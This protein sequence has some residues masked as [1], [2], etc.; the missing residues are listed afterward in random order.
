M[1]LPTRSTLRFVAVLIAAAALTGF[2]R[3][4]SA[5]PLVLLT[6]FPTLRQQHSLTCE[7]SSASMGTRGAVT[8]ARIMAAMSRSPNPNLGFRGNPDGQQRHALVDYGVYAAPVQSALARLGYHSEIVSY[9]NDVQLESY[10][11]QGWPVLVWA[12]YQLQH[13]VPRLA[14]HKGVQFF[15]V[16]HE[17]ALLMVGYDGG[18][19]I[20]NDP[21]TGKVVRYYW[22]E[23]NRSWGYFGNMALAIQPCAMADPVPSVRLKS[24]SAA[25]LTWS[26]T[27][28]RNAA[29]YT[30]TVVRTTGQHRVIVYQAV[31]TVRHVTLLN[32]VA[33]AQYEISVEA[34]SGCGGTTE[35]RRLAVQLPDVLTTPTPA[36]ENTV[37][38]T[39]T[40][41]PAPSPSPTASTTPAR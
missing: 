24:V 17:H 31:Q 33:G 3:A 34:M 2:P 20:A 32:P 29:N 19:I 9:G 25:G 22:P 15:L 11:N 7:S 21:W 18:T 36:P 38:A 30:V 12:T 39:P 35:A 40:T 5:S 16:P 10:L 26:W 14:Q 13:A 37:I 8:E 6:G 4:T 27:Q 28:A 41:T 1:T 23:F